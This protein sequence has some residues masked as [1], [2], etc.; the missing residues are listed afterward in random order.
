MRR[1]RGLTQPEL[2]AM[3]GLAQQSVSKIERGEAC[4]HDQVKLKLAYALSVSPST[5]FPWP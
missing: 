5:L 3:A 4:P 2:A 1:T